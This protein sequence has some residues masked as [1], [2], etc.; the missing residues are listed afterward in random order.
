MKADVG[1]SEK[2]KLAP[3]LEKETKKR[4]KRVFSFKFFATFFKRQR[5]EEELPKSD[6]GKTT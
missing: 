5:S 4:L 1:V 6:F 2:L 3:N